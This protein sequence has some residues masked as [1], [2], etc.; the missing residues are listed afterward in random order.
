MVEYV[1]NIREK[2]EKFNQKKS[3]NLSIQTNHI[4]SSSETIKLTVEIFQ[5]LIQKQK[6]AVHF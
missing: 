4:K 1:E 3:S 2:V 5:L 6:S